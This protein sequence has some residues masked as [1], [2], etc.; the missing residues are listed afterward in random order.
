MIYPN[1]YGIDIIH[2]SHYG[3]GCKLLN[4]VVTKTQQTRASYVLSINAL[5]SIFLPVICIICVFV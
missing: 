4:N 3:K 5:E 1:Y 2:V